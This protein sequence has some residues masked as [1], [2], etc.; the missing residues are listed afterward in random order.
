M[1]PKSTP[2]QN[3]SID[4]QVNGFFSPR[5]RG[6]MDKCNPLFSAPHSPRKVEWRDAPIHPT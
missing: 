3:K 1:N 2:I 5:T 4:R 6:G